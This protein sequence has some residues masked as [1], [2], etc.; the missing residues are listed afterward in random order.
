MMAKNVVYM[1]NQYAPTSKP[2]FFISAEMCMMLRD[3]LIHA[4]AQAN[5]RWSTEALL[6]SELDT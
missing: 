5:A 2:R 3:T 1:E 6:R 4:D